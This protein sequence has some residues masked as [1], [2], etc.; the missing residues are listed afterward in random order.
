[1]KK[2]KVDTDYD[3]QEKENRD[4]LS[5]SGDVPEP[6]RVRRS[7][8]WG[9]ETYWM[10]LLDYNIFVLCLSIPIIIGFLCIA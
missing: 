4:S 10:G 8:S 5:D 7:D 2:K 1:M 3:K 9:D 6:P